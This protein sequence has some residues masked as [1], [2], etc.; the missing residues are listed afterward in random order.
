MAGK[1]SEL[2]ARQIRDIKDKGRYS[3]GGA[4]GLMLQVSKTG[5][6]CWLQ[7][8]AIGGKRKDIGLGGFPAVSLAQA[9]EQA[10]EMKQSIKKGVDPLLQKRANE[11]AL[12]KAQLQQATFAEVATQ[13]H[14]IKKHE[15]KNVKHCDQWINTLKTYAF[16]VI[17]QLPIDS[18]EPTHILKILEEIWVTKTETATRVRQRIAT[19][20]DHALAKGARTKSNPANWN[21][22]LKLLLPAPAKLRKKQG[23]HNRHHPALPSALMHDF[24]A[25]IRQQSTN[26]SKTLELSILC[27]M[28]SSE[29]RLLTWDEVNLDTKRITLADVRM[30]GSL[31]HTIPL[32]TAAIGVLKLMQ[33]KAKKADIPSNYVFPNQ[34]GTPLSDA[35]VGKL[36]RTLNAKR[37]SN[38]LPAYTDPHQNNRVATPHGFRSC[39]K[40]WISENTRYRDEASEL[41]L[42]HVNSDKT[43]AA[44]ARSNLINERTKMMEEWGLFCLNRQV[45]PELLII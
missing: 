8:V 16:P 21:G 9:R 17:G 23:I 39:F 32:S 25:D 19:V 5:A 42:A 13:C 26:T 30:K 43:R 24:M 7:R 2:T 10:R 1:K 15:F 22:C 44:Y 35:I 45:K 4:P 14:N 36:I 18:I 12:I 37:I 33:D 27:A 20:F 38:N 40:D 3:V 41:A 28:R 31:E 29:A 34:K 6:K 11:Q